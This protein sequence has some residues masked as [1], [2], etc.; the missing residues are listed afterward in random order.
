MRPTVAQ[1]PADE[2]RRKL[3]ETRTEQADAGPAPEP[4]TEREPLDERRA[5]VHAKAQEALAAMDALQ[6]PPS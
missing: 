1:D 3:A 4:S 5:R 6:E 2:L